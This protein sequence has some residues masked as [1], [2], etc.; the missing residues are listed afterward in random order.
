MSIL[1]S[2]RLFSI[3]GTPFWIEWRINSVSTIKCEIFQKNGYM[4]LNILCTVWNG[5]TVFLSLAVGAFL[6][7]E[8]VSTFKIISGTK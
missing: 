3:E 5:P 7:Y 8:N 1:P 4:V 6:P 2:T